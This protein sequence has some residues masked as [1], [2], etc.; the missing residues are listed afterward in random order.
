MGNEGGTYLGCLRSPRTQFHNT[1]KVREHCF[2]SNHQMSTRVALEKIH[3]VPF[4][5]IGKTILPRQFHLR[6]Q[7]LRVRT[8]SSKF[9][10]LFSPT[11]CTDEE[12]GSESVTLLA[13][14]H[15]QLR[16]S[17]PGGAPF[18]NPPTAYTSPRPTVIRAI[19]T[20]YPLPPFSGKEHCA[21]DHRVTAKLTFGMLVPGEGEWRW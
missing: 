11:S 13:Q 9:H 4:G 21:C 10:F 17:K 16:D 7:V 14:D 15:T 18:E 19:R 5:E 20:A 1:E 8:C 12:M 2:I 3:H 6:R